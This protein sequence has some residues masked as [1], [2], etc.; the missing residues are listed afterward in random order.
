MIQTSE[1]SQNKRKCKLMINLDHQLG[2]TFYFEVISK[3]SHRN[4][5]AKIKSRR[6]IKKIGSSSSRTD[7]SQAVHQSSG[8]EKRLTQANLVLTS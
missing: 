1:T 4:H 8:L 3:K 6:N 5:E 7:A 2:G